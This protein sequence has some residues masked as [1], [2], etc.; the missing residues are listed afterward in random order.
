M[1]A[2]NGREIPRQSFAVPGLELAR[3]F[4]DGVSREF[5]NLLGIHLVPPRSFLITFRGSAVGCHEKQMP[6]WK[7][8][9]D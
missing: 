9:G 7:S 6:S 2:A 3:Q 1:K 8:Q 4:R 5:C